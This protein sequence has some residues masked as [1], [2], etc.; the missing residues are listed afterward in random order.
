M[1]R[2]AGAVFGACVALA[3]SSAGLAQTTATRSSSFQYDPASGLLTQEVIEPN[4]SALR[5]EKDYGYDTFGNKTSISAS[6]VDITTRASSVTYD[7]KGQFVT[8]NTNALNQSETFQYDARF[9]VA[10]SHT[11]PNGLTTTWQYD[12]FGRKTQETRP[13]GTQTKWV[14]LFCSGV[15]GGTATCVSGASYLIQATPYASNGTTQNGP[16]SIVYFDSLDREIARDT[17]GFD[18]S[19]IRVAKQYDSFGR[20]LKQSRPYFASGGTPQWT[21][22]AYDALGRVVTETNPDNSTT[23]HAYHGLVTT[24]T[25]GLSQT[26]TVTKNSQG[27]VVSVKDAAN[28]TTTYVYDPFG[29]M[30]KTT[31]ALGNVVAATYD[32][33]GRK[34]ASNDPDLGAWTYAYNT[35]D[36]VTS[37][38]DAKSQVT[39]WSYDLIGRMTGRV[40]PDM[41]AAWVYDT[42]PNAIGKL[43]TASIT[44]GAD[45]GYKRSYTYDS[46]GRP[47]TAST[48][49]DGAT[50]TF[51]ASYDANSRLSQINYPSGFA[52]GYTYTA[53]GYASQ[54]SSPTTGQVYWTPNT[55]DAE[56]HLT[57]QTAGNGLVTTQTFSA[58]TGRLLQ[59][60]A[61]SSNSVANFS[62]NYDVLG[63]LTSRADANESLSENLVYDTLN[64]LTQSTVNLT[65]TALVKTFSYNPIGNLLTKSDVGNY[66]YP[67][68]GSALPHAV[69]SISGGTLSTTFA[70]DPNGNQT[71]GVGRTITY[72]SYNKPASITQGSQTLFFSHDPNHDRFKQTTSAGTTTLYFDVFGIH[73]ELFEAAT[74]Q[75]NEYLMVGGALVGVRFERSDATVSTRYFTSDHL[76]SIAVIT[77]ENANVVERL[78]YDAWGKRRFPNGTDDVADSI[79]SQ[80]SRGFT[81]QEELADVGLVHLNGRVYDPLVGRMMS[82]DPFVPDPMNAQAWNRYSYVINNPL[83]ITDPNGYCFLGLCSFF[84]AIGNA[85]SSFF[86]G[87]QN[88]FRSVPILGNLIQIAA[89]AI[90]VASLV[91]APFAPLVAAASAFFVSGVTSGN[92]G[93]ALKAGIVAGLTAL[94]FNAVGDITAKMDGAI[95]G[96]DG[97]H[98][99]FVPFSEGHLAN[100]AG[101]A[102]VGCAS[103]VASGGKCGPG[104]LAAGVTSAAGPIINDP[105]GFNFG[106]LA[107]NA[108]LGGVAS[109]AGGGKFENGAVTAAFG[110]L[111][112]AVFRKGS[113][114]HILDRHGDDAQLRDP[115]AGQFIGE[116]TSPSEL[117]K[118]ADQ[119]IDNPIATAPGNRPGYQILF[120]SVV[121]LNIQTG[122]KIPDIVGFTGTYGGMPNTPTNMV[123]VVVD[124]K[125]QVVTMFPASIPYMLKYGIDPKEFPPWN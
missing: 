1:G 115:N 79:T 17:Q 62:Y 58:L 3:W 116:Y 6:G 120:G 123:A 38:T 101:H 96:L 68:A 51:T 46:L 82:A 89:T 2:I 108:V 44:A 52:L 92:L 28:N 19:T 66:L 88:L 83:S 7:A 55:F 25:N 59:T 21:S 95:P 91:C 77:D 24:D 100:I 124:D 109:V 65:P 114:A 69:S 30:L 18:A 118:L 13:D 36:Q 112:N 37:Q 121:F 94:A 75:W 122:A 113:L 99:T 16:T 105:R 41:T 98:G 8:Q 5:L 48:L 4:T 110:Y 111:F 61:G 90:C 35:L 50:Y 56:M 40:E 125:G 39:T 31:D 97:S 81:G 20:V 103:S 14:Y 53:L 102:L 45:A 26:R 15:N 42:G 9:G 84:K 72:T 106:S 57:Q 12:T 34:V 87:L 27:Q 64:R 32:T 74:S 47:V 11:G 49:E 43:I 70:Y 54:L 73:A 104:A 29:N 78:S 85:I 93:V 80:T 22:F 33:R 86:H 119:I 71:S 117:N 60:Q 23:Q 67:P 76:G 10:T 63:N 107:A